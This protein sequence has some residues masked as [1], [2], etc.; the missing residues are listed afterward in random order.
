MTPVLNVGEDAQ[1]ELRAFSTSPGAQAQDV[2]LPDP[3]DADGRLD[4]RGSDLP[5]ADLDNYRI[6]QDCG[7]DI[8]QRP[9]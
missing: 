8:I 3:S 4:G 6:N 9:V 7:I 5:V 2:L 1:L